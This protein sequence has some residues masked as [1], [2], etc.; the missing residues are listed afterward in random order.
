MISLYTPK[1]EELGFR[2]NLLADEQ[3]MSYN[4]KWGGTLEFPKERWQDWYN[5]WIA[6]PTDG[7]IYVYLYSSQEKEFVGEVACHF[8]EDSSRWLTDVIVH[9][10]F[11]KKGY[12]T[13]GLQLLCE[14]CRQAGIKTLYDNIARDNPSVVLFLNNGFEKAEETEDVILVK[15][16]L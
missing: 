3:T 6:C 5:R 9:S 13:Q 2:Q 16:D 12:G 10:R 11:R 7:R 1:L 4:A 8:D 15:K 14:R